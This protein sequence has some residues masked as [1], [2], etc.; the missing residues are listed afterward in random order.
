[1]LSDSGYV[2]KWEP[3]GK[4]IDKLECGVW[5]KE[6]SQGWLG[7]LSW[8]TGKMELSSTKIGKTSQTDFEG[9]EQELFWMCWA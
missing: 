7:V 9:E 4:I 3:T 1:M 2:L 6:M 5:E 8:A